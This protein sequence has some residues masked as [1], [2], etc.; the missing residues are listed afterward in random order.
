MHSHLSSS[1]LDECG[2]LGRPLSHEVFTAP[3]TDAIAGDVPRFSPADSP[4]LAARAGHVGH[5]LPVV[6]VLGDGVAGSG[7]RMYTSAYISPIGVRGAT[8]PGHESR[9]ISGRRRTIR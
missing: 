2:G 9:C 5:G 8:I 6:V 3:V 4:G 1:Q 7:R